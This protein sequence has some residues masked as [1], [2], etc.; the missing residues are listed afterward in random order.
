MRIERC[1]TSIS[2]IPSEAVPGFARLPFTRGL[3]HYDPPPPLTLLDLDR[4]RRRGEFRFA[5][6]LRAFIDVEDGRI[7]ASGYSGGGVMGVT[8]ISAGRLRFMMPA[9]GNRDIQRPPQATAGAVTFVQTSGGR[10]GFSFLK[11]T[12]RPPFV[13]T[14]P[15]TIW[16]TISLTIDISG[17][18]SCAVLGASP[19]PRHL[20]YDETGRLVQKTALT[21]FRLW[22]R[23]V[24]G[25]HTPWGGE[26]LLPALAI[27]ESELERQLSERIMSSGQRPAVRSLRPGDFLFRQAAGDTSIAL[28]LDGSLEVQVDGRVVG[29]V[30]PGA[31]VGERSALEGGGRT[32]DLRA[33]TP[34]R[35]A[36]VPAGSID[37]EDLGELAQGHRR[38]ADPA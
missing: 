15:F 11:P 9:R 4:M 23:T 29:R 17:N 6:R 16:T 31:V 30:G 20:L 25:S 7:A 33:L 35:V 2:W 38:E 37:L 18:C 1:V 13:V 28:V 21:R 5:N 8:P 26:D 27:P 12:W 14:Q 32:A 36:E 34:V 3:M 19:F 10:P 24:F 22:S